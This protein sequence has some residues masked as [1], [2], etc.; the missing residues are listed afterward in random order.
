ME[1][2]PQ[3]STDHPWSLSH[4]IPFSP[5]AQTAREVILCSECL[6]PRVVYSQ[7]KFSVWD[8]HALVRT[9]EGIFFTCGS[10][11]QGLEVEVQ[12]GEDPSVATLFNRVFVRENLTCDMSIEVPYYSSERFAKICTSCGCTT[13]A[14]EEGQYPLCGYCKAVEAGPSWRERENCFPSHHEYFFYIFV[15]KLH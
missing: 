6:K 8:E 5:N 12:P 7:R 1:H 3:N 14:Q 10:S 13:D 4:G 2:S 9:V 11:L 15:V